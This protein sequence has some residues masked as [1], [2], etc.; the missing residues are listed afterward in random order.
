MSDFD[1]K[2]WLRGFADGEGCF[3]FSHLK[4]RPFTFRFVFK[5]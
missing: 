4:A 5:N 2:E 1:F 3:L